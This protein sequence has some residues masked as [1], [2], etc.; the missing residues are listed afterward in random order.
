MS[1][2]F[3]PFT[4]V[5]SFLFAGP[6]PAMTVKGAKNQHF[7]TIIPSATTVLGRY[8]KFMHK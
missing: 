5:I 8:V 4:V 7:P 1:K 6:M 3:V 2:F